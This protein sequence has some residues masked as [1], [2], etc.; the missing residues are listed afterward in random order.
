MKSLIALSVAAAVAVAQETFVST[1]N[2]CWK[3]EGG[4]FLEECSDVY[5]HNCFVYEVDADSACNVYTFS[6]SRATW[7]SQDIR[8]QL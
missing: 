1:N 8:A 7:Y 4:R 2:E 3:E 6:D 5:Y